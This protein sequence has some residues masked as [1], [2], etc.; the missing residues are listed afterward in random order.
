MKQHLLSEKLEAIFISF[1]HA[2]AAVYVPPQYISHSFSHLV[3][4]VYPLFIH[5]V[6]PPLPLISANSSHPPPPLLPNK[7]LNNLHVFPVSIDS[8][9]QPSQPAYSFPFLSTYTRPQPVHYRTELSTTL[10]AKMRLNA[11]KTTRLEKNNL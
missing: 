3:I 10:E 2:A 1:A 4:S 8:F 7:P 5:S 9:S 11:Y 6:Y